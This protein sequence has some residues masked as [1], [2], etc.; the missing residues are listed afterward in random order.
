VSFVVSIL[1]SGMIHTCNAKPVFQ[2]LILNL[3]GVILVY[4]AK[5][6]AHYPETLLID[7]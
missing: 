5:R 3:A 7:D 4:A 2:P 6:I 1:L